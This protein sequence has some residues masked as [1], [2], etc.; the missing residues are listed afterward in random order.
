[1]VKSREELEARLHELEERVLI[2]DQRAIERQHTEGKL[3]A[4][5]RIDGSW[6]PTRSSKSS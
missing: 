3:T 6:T 5:E 1:M 4:R 2:G